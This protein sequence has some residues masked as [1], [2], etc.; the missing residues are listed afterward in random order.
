MNII[1]IPDPKRVNKKPESVEILLQSG[2]FEQEGFSVIKVELRHYVE[3][4]DENLGPYSLITSYVETDKGSIE[5]IYDEGFR[6]EDSL[7]RTVQFLVSNLGI[8]G[9]ILRSLITLRNNL[10]KHDG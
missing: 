6:G 5:M 2:N 10:T 8:S 9:L 4:R 1:D 3:K 7:T